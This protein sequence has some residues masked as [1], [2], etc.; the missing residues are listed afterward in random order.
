M[1]HQPV[2]TTA[3]CAHARHTHT[4]T[5]RSPNS[6]LEGEKGAG[7]GLEGSRS[8]CRAMGVPICVC[9][10]VQF[11]VVHF[12]VDDNYPFLEPLVPAHT[13][14]YKKVGQSITLDEAIL[15]P[16]LHSVKPRVSFSNTTKVGVQSIEYGLE[17][18]RAFCPYISFVRVPFRENIDI[19]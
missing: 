15:L 1:R 16:P 18:T 12:I 9:V 19:F 3:S 7:Q 13:C 6:T 5:T 17:T 14:V 11:D 8:F 4:H 2:C 10:G